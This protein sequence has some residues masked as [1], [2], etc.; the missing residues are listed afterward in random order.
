MIPSFVSAFLNGL[1]GVTS[2]ASFSSLLN[3]LV[4]GALGSI[5]SDRRLKSD[6]VAVSWSR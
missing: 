2:F 3:G 1:S 5:T 6:V 4:S